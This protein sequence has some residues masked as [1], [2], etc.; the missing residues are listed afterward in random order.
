MAHSIGVLA[1]DLGAQINA[2]IPMCAERTSTKKA[3]TVPDAVKPAAKAAVKLASKAAG[4]AGRRGRRRR[5][6]P[7]PRFVLRQ[8]TP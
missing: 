2:L 7:W 1:A 3:A 4:K 5:P 6:Q 8:P